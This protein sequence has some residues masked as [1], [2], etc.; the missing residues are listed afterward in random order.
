MVAGSIAGMDSKAGSVTDVV[1]GSGSM[2]GAGLTGSSA[3]VP[4]TVKG[5]P[6]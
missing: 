6:Q 2:A 5:D 1:L 3:L 4:Q